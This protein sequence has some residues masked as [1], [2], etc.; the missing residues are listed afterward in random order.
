MDQVVSNVGNAQQ[1]V[2]RKSPLHSEIPG[3][4][5]TALECSWGQRTNCDVAGRGDGARREA[6]GSRNQLNSFGKA[7][8]S[9]GW[10]T[11]RVESSEGEETGD[12]A[13]SGRGVRSADR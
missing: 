11:C 3:L 12:V 4:N 2:A 10:V 1:H 7:G 13:I 5:I 6:R 9:V 8:N